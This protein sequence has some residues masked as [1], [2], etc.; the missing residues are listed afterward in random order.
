[1]KELGNWYWFAGLI[2]IVA[3]GFCCVWGKRPWLENCG[4]P[5]GVFIFAA[6]AVILVSALIRSGLFDPNADTEL[7]KRKNRLD[8]NRVLLRSEYEAA[9]QAA[10]EQGVET[11]KLLRLTWPRSDKKPRRGQSRTKG[12][13]AR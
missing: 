2:A 10:R 6:A 7:R 13:G 4:S 12:M 3:L 1:M 5:P 9:R 8:R 11:S